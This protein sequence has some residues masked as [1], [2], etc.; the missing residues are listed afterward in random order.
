MVEQ[1]DFDRIALFVA[2]ARELRQEPFMSEDNHDRLTML[3][4]SS[5]RPFA[6]FCHPA[7]LKSAILP[8][9][10]L[11]LQSERCAFE[12]VLPLV[13]DNH[14]DQSAAS[15]YRKFALEL[16]FRRLDAPAD[17]DWAEES[18]RQILDI[19]IYTQAIHA[20][21]RENK[22]GKLV[23]RDATLQ[24]FDEWSI[25]IGREK[26]EYLFR[27][28]LKIV[29][30]EYVQFLTQLAEPLFQKLQRDGMKPGFEA[31]AAL[32]FNPYPHPMFRISFDDVFWHLDK[33]TM[34]ETFD[35]LLA[36]NCYRVMHGLLR[37]LFE[38]NRAAALAALCQCSSL[39]E[40][41]A[42]NQ[43]TFLQQRPEFSGEFLCRHDVG[44]L[45]QFGPIQFDVLKGRKV[46][47]DQRTR[48]VFEDL[49][50]D[51][52][53]CF[54]QERDRQRPHRSSLW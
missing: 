3:D 14:F 34:E 36:R 21:Q 22:E 42:M 15:T 33:E 12:K 23:K 38:Q 8:F 19:W 51:F 18:T 4:K 53:Q 16:F 27:V 25:R 2:V 20:G 37:G 54:F 32:E 35:R 39:T 52:R 17:K 40:L 6:Q 24:Q 31:Q 29:G 49:Y 10:R 48:S 45:S 1:K 7:F 41:V 28:S 11:W 5:E 43:V 47:I 30:S 26:F 9:R 44:V 13:L 46:W 50:R